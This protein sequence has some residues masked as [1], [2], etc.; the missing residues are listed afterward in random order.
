MLALEQNI[1]NGK[2]TL[3]IRLEVSDPD[4]VFELRKHREGPAREDYASSAL[5]LGVLALRQAAGELDSTTIRAAA[6]HMLTDL[7]QLLSHRGTDIT[8]EISG[9]LRQYFDPSSG[10]LP[11]RIEALLRNDGELDRA[12]RAHLAPENST[13]AQA[14]AAHFG[15]GS[16]I[17]KLLSPTDAS[18]VKAQVEGVLETLH[19]E[20][21]E[22]IMQ[23]FSL[24]NK[25][26][27]LSR[28]VAE[29]AASNGELKTDL[30]TKVDSLVDEF[31]LD[32][33]ESALSRL[34]GRVE[35]AHKAITNEF[36]ADNEHSAIAR[37]SRMLQETSQ[38]I[39]K[40]LTLDD[41]GSA[42]A[43]LKRELLTTIES[44]VTSNSSFQSEVRTTLA[45]LQARKEEAARSTRHGQTFEEQIGLLIATEAQRLNDPHE[46]AGMT[47]GAIKNCKTGDFVT[48]LGPDSAAPGARVVWEAKEDKSYDLKRA[49]AEIELA[50]KNRQ[51]QIGV[52]VFSRS[53]APEGLQPFAR[54]G[55]D[56]VI[57][58]DAEN[59]D[60]DLNVRVAYSVARALVIR[61]NHESIESEQAL[62]AI[63][64]ATRAIE[65]QLEHL[66]Q[67][68]I[69]A[70]TV[71]SNG[72]KVVERAAKMR[73]DLAKEVDALDRQVSGL[74]TTG[75]RA[76]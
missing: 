48:T 10:A 52:F 63:D 20:Q 11:Q 22:H 9:A 29:L 30:K 70:E 38:Q 28:L 18:G 55:S 45:T 58:W 73:S 66:D 16:A 6:Q 60:S 42:L 59:A 17:F 31:S 61:E 74:K 19:R 41:D 62:K 13:I 37:L 4:V 75:A 5:R 25:Q 15:E 65:K 14:L 57:T 21:R 50:R 56:I 35:I 26:S 24:D 54:Y 36:S 44:L 12:L 23:E 40:H 53:T 46:L 43:R 64:I 34:V 67:I 72:E 51:A 39:N 2:L 32:R 68:K 69:W 71:R 1:E 76:A 47:T 3:E 8:N 33:P 27:A 49:L 7:G